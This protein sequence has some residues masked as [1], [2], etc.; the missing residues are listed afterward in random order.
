[1]LGMSMGGMIAQEFAMNHPD[2][3]DALVLTATRPPAPSYSG[4]DA[5]E[6][7]W[8]M[9]RPPGRDEPLDVY[10]LRL[11][12]GSTGEGFALR[13]PEALDELV[14]Q[15]VERPTPRAMLLHQLRAVNGWG[16]AERLA[17]ITAPTLV[18]H[19]DQDSMLHV[20]NGR[21]LGDLIPGARYVELEGVGHLPPLEAPDRLVELIDEL[22][23]PAAATVT[24]INGRAA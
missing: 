3:L 19:G 13:E 8:G 6:S 10:L 9:L 20:E 21:R 4:L 1:V 14:A 15:I 12:G 23:S 11:W 5:S 24:E 22:V 18:V 16:H 7:L 2:R 17:T